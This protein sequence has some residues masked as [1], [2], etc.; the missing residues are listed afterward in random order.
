M[1]VARERKKGRE[2]GKEG[3]MC[4]EGVKKRRRGEG[5]LVP[6]REREGEKRRECFTRS[7]RGH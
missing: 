5:E 1:L 4:C 3:I 6:N 2:R 7:V